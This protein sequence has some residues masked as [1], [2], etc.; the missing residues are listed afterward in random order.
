MKKFALVL[1][2]SGEIG[3]A[4]CQSLAEDGWSLYV[5]YSNNKEA[6][7]TLFCALSEN[8][9]AGIYACAGGFFKNYSSTNDCLTYF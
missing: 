8:F 1:G 9:Y 3:R 5:H 4:I 7:Q 2:A 6:A